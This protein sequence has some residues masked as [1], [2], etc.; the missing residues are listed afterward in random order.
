MPVCKTDFNKRVRKKLTSFKRSVKNKNIEFI[1][2]DF[3][4]IKD[5]DL[6]LIYVKM[7]LF[8]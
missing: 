7:I 6:R 5:L 1:H 4:V 3:K 8:I 2:S